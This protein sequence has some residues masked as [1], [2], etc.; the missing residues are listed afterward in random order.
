MF[1]L[2]LDNP[3]SLP[4]GKIAGGPAFYRGTFQIAETGETFLDMSQWG[5]GAVWVNGHN[6]GRYWDMGAGRSLYL[7]SPWQ[8]K[9]AHEIVVLEL[10]SNPPRG[11]QIQ[12]T[13]E[14]IE[15]APVPFPGEE[16]K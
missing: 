1:S 14:F 2:P 11:L 15:T 5:F 9:G 3:I 4:Q 7:P 16:K 13:T 6:L 12:G 8:K 10:E